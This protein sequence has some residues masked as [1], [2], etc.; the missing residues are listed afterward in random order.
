MRHTLNEILAILQ[1]QLCP[2]QDENRPSSSRSSNSNSKA[3]PDSNFP[4]LVAPL[5]PVP[6]R[7][8]ITTVWSRAISETVRSSGAIDKLIYKPPPPKPFQ[9]RLDTVLLIGLSVP[10]ASTWNEK[11]ANDRKAAQEVLGL[12]GIS[13][14]QVSGT[15]RFLPSKSAPTTAT[16]Q[17]PPLRVFLASKSAADDALRRAHTLKSTCYDRVFVKR[18]LANED[19]ETDK[20]ARQAR[21][22]QNRLFTESNITNLK[23]IVSNRGQVGRLLIVE[24]KATASASTSNGSEHCATELSSISTASTASQPS[25]QTSATITA[26]SAAS[27]SVATTTKAAAITKSTATTTTTATTASSAS[28]S[29]TSSQ[30]ATKTVAAPQKA[31]ASRQSRTDSKRDGAS[32]TSSQA[33]T[34]ERV[35]SLSAAEK[36][37]KGGIPKKTH[38]NVVSK[39]A[40]AVALLKAAGLPFDE[41]TDGDEVE[42][43]DVAQTDSQAAASTADTFSTSDAHGALLAS[44]SS[45]SSSTSSFSTATTT[46]E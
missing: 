41:L 1:R 34:N 10:T 33:S 26:L 9:T 18:D 44:A 22:E 27:S 7:P 42:D 32:A 37:K 43:M 39:L 46:I 19:K 16:T 38:A 21:D 31:Q 40:T 4:T 17:P 29:S 5:N 6:S 14:N 13:H 12:L 35:R 28:A 20:S 45:S 25:A 36:S 3:A 15:Y 30:A 2:T 23:C 24:K 11:K 8:A